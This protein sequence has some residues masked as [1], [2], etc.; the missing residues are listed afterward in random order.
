[1]RSLISRCR[2]FL[3]LPFIVTAVTVSP[4]AAAQAV[5]DS[6]FVGALAHFDRARL[7]D[8]DQIEAA[9]KGFQNAPRDP[10]WQPVYSAYLGSAHALKAK[11]AWLPWKKMKLTD[12]GLDHIDQA[13][14]AL[15]PEH[16]RVLVR[17]TPLSLETRLVAA[18]T[19]VAVPDGLFHRRA[20]GKA[21]LADMRRNPLLAAAPASF[22]GELAALEAR[23]QESE[24]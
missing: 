22:R 5:P 1:M 21:L 9:I 16:D 23:L 24:K 8:N 14:A 3:L 13:L 7:G 17:G 4:P 2:L 19:F 20:A 15:H 6:A 12:Q 11:A 18:A 10:Q